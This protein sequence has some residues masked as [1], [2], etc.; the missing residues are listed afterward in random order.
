MQRHPPSQH[1][2]ARFAAKEA[3]EK[4]WAG[5][6]IAVYN[7]MKLVAHE[8]ACNLSSCIWHHAE[9]AGADGYPHHPSASSHLKSMATAIV[10]LEL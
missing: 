10:I 2:A 7:G 6:G 4:P 3:F 9:N 8:K 5:D 1:Y